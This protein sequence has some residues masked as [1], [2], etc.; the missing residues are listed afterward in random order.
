MLVDA[1]A[2]LPMFVHWLPVRIPWVWKY[3]VCQSAKVGY[4]LWHGVRRDIFECQGR[5]CQGA[6][7]TTGF[8][9]SDLLSKDEKQDSCRT[10]KKVIGF[11]DGFT[12]LQTWQPIE[13]LRQCEAEYCSNCL[14]FRQCKK[15]VFSTEELSFSSLCLHEKAYGKISFCSPAHSNFLFS[16]HQLRST[17]NKL[18]Q[19]LWYFM[20][21]LEKCVMRAT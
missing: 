12:A 13:R 10:R 18:G 6:S 21:L 3:G 11:T 19:V 8:N 7:V 4:V 17:A 16:Y 15:F 5:T 9:K 14:L 20:L 2:C 1:I